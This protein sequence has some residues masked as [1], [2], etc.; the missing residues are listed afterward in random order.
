MPSNFTGSG[1][2]S[3]PP[4]AVENVLSTRFSGPTS[5][6]NSPLVDALN[7]QITTLAGSS[8]LYMQQFIASKNFTALNR[9][10]VTLD[11]FASSFASYYQS[12]YPSPNPNVTASNVKARFSNAILSYTGLDVAEIDGTLFNESEAVS[13]SVSNTVGTTTDQLKSDI[14]SRAFSDFLK[15][16]DY[17]TNPVA[18]V[19]NSGFSDQLNKYFFHLASTLQPDSSTVTLSTGAGAAP[20]GTLPLNFEDIYNAFF[21][22]SDANFKLTVGV[23]LK[24]LLYATDSTS[25]FLPSN[26]VGNWLKYISDSYAKALSG[27]PVGKSSVSGSFTKVVIIE[28]IYAL[29]VE[30][31][32]TLQQLAASQSDRLR[33][34]TQWQQAYT[35]LQTQLP[36][37]IKNDGSALGLSQTSRDEANKYSQATLES[38]TSRRSVIQDDA[39]ALQSTLNQSNDSANQQA[40]MGTAIIQELS[41]ILGAIY[42]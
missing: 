22:A 36:T 23:Y 29:I 11:A 2:S 39:K 8:N 13:G 24:N 5:L 40:N 16:F 19:S 37:F 30:M 14:A 32:G 25:S 10:P 4:Y 7:A 42:R 17:G 20:A 38:I 34:L 6:Q 9:M 12:N 18:L 41:T 1:T 35:K 26:D 31:V 15:N 27:A 21:P 33:V 3:D 28:K